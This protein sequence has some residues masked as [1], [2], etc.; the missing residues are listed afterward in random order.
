MVLFIIVAVF[1]IVAGLAFFFGSTSKRMQD[2][3]WQEELEARERMKQEDLEK[4]K[5][6]ESEENQRILAESVRQLD[7][8]KQEGQSPLHSLFVSAAG[9]TD[10]MIVGE[11]SDELLEAVKTANVSGLGGNNDTE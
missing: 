3:Q 2:K 5:Q 4:Q 9:K 10:N 11:V 8:P 6:W 1:V 7:R